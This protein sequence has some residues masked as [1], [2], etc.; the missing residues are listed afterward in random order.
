MIIDI[1]IPVLAESV[2]DATLLEWNNAVGDAVRAGDVLIELET[3]KVV[4]EVPAPESGVLIDIIKH[5]GDVAHSEEVIAHIDTEKVSESTSTPAPTAK[6]T[7]PE[8]DPGE[9]RFSPAVA[10]LINEKGL[11]PS[12]IEGTGRDG[13]LAKKDVLRALNKSSG[14]PDLTTETV[15][16]PSTS[17]PPSSKKTLTVPGDRRE[18]REPMSRMR[19][20]IA[21]R[22]VQ[23]QQT[24]ASLT[25]FN[26]VNMGPVTAL[27]RQYKERFEKAHGVRLGLM[28]FFAKASVAAL[29]RFP[30]INA[31]IVGN[32]IV[33]HDFYDIGIAVNSPKGLVVPVLR[34]V[35]TM[36]FADIEKHI[37]VFGRRAAAGTLTLEDM[38]DGTFTLSNGGIFGSLLSTPILNPPQSGILGM[39]K[40]E[41]RAVVEKGEII[42][43]P[44]MYLALSYDHRI[45]DGRGAVQFLS[46]IKEAIEDPARMLLEI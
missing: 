34:H 2:P 42:I 37:A 12:V 21:E 41:D 5:P 33:Y 29:Q 40:I 45:V 7:P 10:R 23:S 22:L 38:T 43:R 44:M 46:V 39:H 11:D 13:R 6:R 30:E 26:E 27:R 20:R 18:R 16:N 24:T 9:Y 4:L 19:V 25:T 36:S 14:A 32:D 15:L 31:Y 8:T 3:D 17:L 35:E 28:S 1:T